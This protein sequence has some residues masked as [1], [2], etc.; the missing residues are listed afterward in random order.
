VNEKRGRGSLREYTIK[1]L[2]KDVAVWEQKK[3]KKKNKA[4]CLKNKQDKHFNYKKGEVETL[5]LETL[6]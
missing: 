2:T 3:K 4:N 6:S 1:R 5:A